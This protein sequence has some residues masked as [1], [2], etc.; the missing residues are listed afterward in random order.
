MDITK[1]TKEIVVKVTTQKDSPPGQH[2]GIFAQVY[3]PESGEQMLHQIG[4][5]VL[6]IDAPPPPAANQ[7]AVGRRR[8]A[9]T[10]CSTSQDG[11]EALAA[12]EA[13]TGTGGEGESSRGGE[14]VMS[15]CITILRA[16]T[17]ERCRWPS[18]QSKIASMRHYSTFWNEQADSVCRGRGQC[19]RCLHEFRS[20]RIAV[21]ATKDVDLMIRRNGSAHES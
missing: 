9:A 7:P 1:D 12:G 4:G 3:I 16:D 5:T 11:E 17:W 21:R 15:A 2:Q 6:R 20:I 19:C 18:T 13:A 8:N 14:A 10:G